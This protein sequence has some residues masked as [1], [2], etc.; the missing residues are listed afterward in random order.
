LSSRTGSVKIELE[1]NR[2]KMK[3]LAILTVYNEVNYL[4]HTFEYFKRNGCDIYVIDN[5]SNDGTYE[6]LIE[7]NI[8]CHRVDTQESF[9]LTKLQKEIISTVH[10]IK[11]DWVVYTGADMY[12]VAD[13]PLNEYIKKIDSMGFNQISTLA[14]SVFNTGENFD[15][16]L[17]EHYFYATLSIHITMIS[18]YDES[19]G[20]YA[21][22]VTINNAN[23]FKADDCICVN[24]GACKPI[25]EQEIRLERR[26]RAWENGLNQWYGYHYIEG[27]QRNWIR[28][29]E[30]CIDLRTI[31][32]Y[33]YIQKI[34][35]S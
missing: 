7:N 18:K 24:Y 10:Q 8:P 1:N 29:K 12:Y 32:E 26:K 19:Y 21:D 15:L 20:M 33:K 30:E 17:C 6:W 35:K 11:P 31:S 16:P 14:Y 9:D 4:P 22:V 23:C 34:I 27:K 2:I 5:Y 25:E 28:S 13:M 3:I